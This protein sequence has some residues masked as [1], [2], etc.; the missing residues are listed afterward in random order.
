MCDSHG[1]W[2]QAQTSLLDY[3][4]SLDSVCDRI[5]RTSYLSL[6][7]RF[8]GFTK[9]IANTGHEA[10]FLKILLTMQ[11]GW[12]RYPIASGIPSFPQTLVD[13]SQPATSILERHLAARAAYR[14]SYDNMLK[15]C[16]SVSSLWS[17]PDGGWDA[18]L[19]CLNPH[20]LPTAIPL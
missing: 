5:R 2:I 10:D 20:S 17:S 14:Q 12:H 11:F 1:E 7:E 18:V 13:S 19:E 3:V 15:D 4:R 8:F 6:L 16:V 9:G